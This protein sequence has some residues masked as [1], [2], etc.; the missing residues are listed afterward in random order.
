V[1]G[2]DERRELGESSATSSDERRDLG[3]ESPST[4]RVVE[5]R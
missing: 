2:D 5:L 4:G 3:D 1:L